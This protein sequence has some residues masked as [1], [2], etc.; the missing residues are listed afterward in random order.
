[1]NMNFRQSWA[2]ATIFATTRQCCEAEKLSLVALSQN[3][4][5]LSHC[6]RKIVANFFLTSEKQIESYNGM[7]Q[8]VER[9][10]AGTA[11]VLVL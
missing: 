11:A 7:A 8:S 3:I 10:T 4:R 2:L 9:W 5:K 1:M 6:R